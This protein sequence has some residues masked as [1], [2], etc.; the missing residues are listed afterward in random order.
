MKTYRF[1]ITVFLFALSFNLF[2]QYENTSSKNNRNSNMQQMPKENRWFAGGM[3]GGGFSTNNSY[4]EISP[5]I[6]YHL[7]PAMDVGTRLTYIYRGYRYY[8]GGPKYNSHIYGGGI[9]GRYKFLKFLMAHVE[10]AG[11]SNQW[12]DYYGESQRHW[13]NSLYVGGGLYQSLGG[14]GFA[15]ITVLYDVFEDEYSP[16]NN[17]LIRIGFGMG[18]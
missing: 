5:I 1:Y 4:F 10:Y 13:V 12:Y 8:Q 6:G 9:F 11:L 15:T 2:A 16:Y 18:F 7:T 14:R 3:I 17:P